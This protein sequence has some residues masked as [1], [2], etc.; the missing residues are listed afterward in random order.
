MRDLFSIS[1]DR[2]KAK[3]I[4]DESDRLERHV[5]R[6]ARFVAT[7]ERHVTPTLLATE[8]PSK[9]P[10]LVI[11]ICCLDALDPKFEIAMTD[12]AGSTL[13]LER[14]V[15]DRPCQ[16]P[17][18][19]AYAEGN[20][21]VIL[22]VSPPDLAILVSIG[23]RRIGPLVNHGGV[24]P[25]R[26]RKTAYP[27]APH[28]PSRHARVGGV[29][30]S[31]PIASAALPEDRLDSWPSRGALRSV[32][33]DDLGDRSGLHLTRGNHFVATIDQRGPT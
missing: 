21:V 3:V 1:S 5:R 17:S 16:R 30:L 13:R 29:A 15:V 27:N 18:F 2:R 22:G 19:V 32:S 8:D 11:V 24:V 26:F 10:R 12:R 28:A 7:N 33:E 6:A 25:L 31:R 14:C 4:L 23:M 20:A 9:I